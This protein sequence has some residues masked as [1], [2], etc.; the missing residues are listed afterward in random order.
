MEI[1]IQTTLKG[2]AAEKF[3][4][5]MERNHRSIAGEAA[6]RLEQSLERDCAASEAP[7]EE[8]R[9]GK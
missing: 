5:S 7:C 4:A 3:V 8:G 2:A 6:Y 1:K 9:G